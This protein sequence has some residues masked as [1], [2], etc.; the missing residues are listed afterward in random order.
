MVNLPIAESHVV[1]TR[2]QQHNLRYLEVQSEKATRYAERS[3]YSS[4]AFTAIAVFLVATR[5]PA[6]TQREVNY[7]VERIVAEW[8]RGARREIQCEHS[9]L[10]VGK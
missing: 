10:W 5:Y 4:L 6:G 8:L 9:D 2:G 1:V 7:S 3:K